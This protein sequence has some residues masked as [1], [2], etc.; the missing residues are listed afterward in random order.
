MIPPEKNRRAIKAIH[1]LMIRLKINIVQEL[2][3]RELYNLIDELEYLPILLLNKEDRTQEFEEYLEKICSQFQCMRI[4][5]QYQDEEE[6][7]Y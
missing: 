3:H 1:N 6:P 5:E 7:Y 2:P 4:W